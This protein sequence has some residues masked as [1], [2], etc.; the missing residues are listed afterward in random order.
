MPNKIKIKQIDGLRDELNFLHTGDATGI[1]T[2][3]FFTGSGETVVSEIGGKLY[4]YTPSPTS[5]L[6]EDYFSGSGRTSVSALDG[7]I[8]IATNYDSQR[9]QYSSYS[10]TTG[11]SSFQLGNDSVSTLNHYY[12][13]DISDN[14]GTRI[15]IPL[16]TGS[17]VNLAKYDGQKISVS[18]YNNFSGYDQE[19]SFH[20]GYYP[21]GSGFY[22]GNNKILSFSGQITGPDYQYYQKAEFVYNSNTGQSSQEWKLFSYKGMKI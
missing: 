17:L 3:N 19:I 21:L 4:F 7:K 10:Q 6:T 2:N 20:T 11:A 16:R 18:L 14:T 15:V 5:I 1:V 12:D 8:I 22:T 13:I 9:N